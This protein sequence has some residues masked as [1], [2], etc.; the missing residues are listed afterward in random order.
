MP[1]CQQGHP[2]AGLQ[3]VKGMTFIFLQNKYVICEFES[4]VDIEAEIHRSGRLFAEVKAEVETFRR[5]LGHGFVLLW[6]LVCCS[7]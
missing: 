2:P 6:L 1:C 3:V 4:R 5:L 7:H